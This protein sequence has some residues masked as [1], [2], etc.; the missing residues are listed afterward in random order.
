MKTEKNRHGT[1]PSIFRF[2]I[3]L[4]VMVVFCLLNW[5]TIKAEDGKDK[6]NSLDIR[7]KS[8]LEPVKEAELIIEDWML[9]IEVY[10]VVERSE[11]E[12]PLENW[13]IQIPEN[14]LAEKD[15]Y[16]PALESWL[17]ERLALYCAVESKPGPRLKQ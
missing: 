13:M 10:L 16:A 9:T 5:N 8:A 12:I 3:Y 17:M 4:L 11:E 14:N 1:L 2:L 15:E 7:L 6:Q